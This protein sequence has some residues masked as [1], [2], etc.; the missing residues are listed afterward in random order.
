[1]VM[2]RVK[3]KKV[4]MKVSTTSDV[5]HIS[6]GDDSNHS[7]ASKTLGDSNIKKGANNETR[8]HD[9]SMGLVDTSEH[10]S[11]DK[12]SNDMSDEEDGSNEL[13]VAKE[14]E[15]GNEKEEHSSSSIY[16]I[17]LKFDYKD[18]QKKLPH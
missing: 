4:T 18:T 13:E 10:D 11:S 1:M 9:K 17:R 14:N 8:E 6:S 5:S 3:K 15:E 16:I 2:T 7:N 12:N